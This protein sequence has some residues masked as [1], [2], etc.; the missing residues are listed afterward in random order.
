MLKKLSNLLNI[1]KGKVAIGLQR[2][3]N[4]Y[5]QRE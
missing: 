2:W 1:L 4:I 3:S 5:L